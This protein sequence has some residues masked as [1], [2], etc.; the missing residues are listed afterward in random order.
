M[1]NKKILIINQNSGYLTIDVAN[2][3]ISKYDEVVMMFGMN[4]ITERNFHPNIKIQ[5]TITYDR[6]TIFKRLWTW[7]ICFMHICFLL[8][9]K[10]RGYTILYYT[11]PPMSYFASLFF[12]NPFGIVV[13][14]TYPNSL[15]LIG[16]KENSIVYKFWA[17]LN[18]K[19]FNKALKII[20][21]S[22]GMKKQLLEYVH[23]DKI[24]AISIW[25]AS[26]NFKPIPKSQ[27][28]F[29]KN[30]SIENKFVVLYSGNLG[31]GH[32]L[33]ILIDVAERTQNIEDIL[34]L[35][36]GEGAKKSKLQE[37]SKSKD[38]SNVVFLTWQSA[39]ILPFSLASADIAIVAI[40]T[41]ST[42]V[43]LPSKTFN[44]MA[45]GAP[46][47]GIGNEGSELESLIN[48]YEIGAYENGDDILRIIDYIIYLYENREK[49]MEISLNSYNTSKRFSYTE[50][51]KYLF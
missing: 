33:E 21:I 44:Y 1:N 20:T 22:E 36:I 42:F 51:S 43:S 7:G 11:N 50:S 38:L 37:M 32:K 23:A 9:W 15:K 16:I 49:S 24:H 39:D 12:S 46:I 41:E 25:P 34:F 29:L 30:H 40:E 47:L 2:S 8:V 27:N 10:Y 35:F 45:V 31:L 18:R 26:E 4:K 6:S 3:F 13:F 48:K 17:Y 14:D 5:K 19:L 28:I